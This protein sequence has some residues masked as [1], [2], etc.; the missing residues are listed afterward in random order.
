M[1]PISQP[2]RHNFGGQLRN[3]R[4]HRRL[5]Q[6]DFALEAEISQKHLSFIES[7]RAHPSRDMVLKLAERLSLPLRERNGL[8][9]AAGFAPVFPERSFDDPALEPVRAAVAAILRGHEPFPALAV[10]RHWTLVS[11]NRA[12]APLLSLSGDASL[13]QPPVNVLRLALSPGGIA[14]HIANFAEWRGHVLDRLRQQAVATGD[15]VLVGLH[16]ELSAYPSPEGPGLNEARDPF[17]GI[18]APLRLK[19]P[20]GLLSLISTTTIFGTSRD[21]ILSELAVEAFF[22]ADDATARLLHAMM[23]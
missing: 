22:P 20:A 21:V 7:G 18:A 8:L 13:I 12:V 23:A 9:L 1:N 14:P 17:A 2:S 5:S 16:T 4:K 19:T 15:A 11:A 10:D 6:L 3:W